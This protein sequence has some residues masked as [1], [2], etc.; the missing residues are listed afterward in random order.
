MLK[1]RKLSKGLILPFPED[2]SHIK[3]FHCPPLPTQCFQQ[4]PGTARARRGRARS[5]APPGQRARTRRSPSRSRLRPAAGELP[6]GSRPRGVAFEVPAAAAPSSSSSASFAAAS[7]PQA[8]CVCPWCQRVFS[9][10][11]NL[12][13][14]M[15][16]HTGEKPHAC[17]LCPYR[18]VQKV[19]VIQHI[20]SK[21]SMDKDLSS[22]FLEKPADN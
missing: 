16:T 12:K 15:L 6:T 21:H 1:K 5:F 22:S 20:R 17:P 7:A 11:S 8:Q 14:H 10:S 13:R 2:K 19:Q 3:L 4:K 18:A 9:K